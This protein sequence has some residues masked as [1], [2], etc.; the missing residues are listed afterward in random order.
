MRVSYGAKF[1]VGNALALHS[2]LSSSALMATFKAGLRR[3][4]RVPH[5]ISVRFG[6]QAGCHAAGRP[7]FWSHR[8]PRP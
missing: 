6:S 1:E 8:K 2:K 7:P 5:G 4:V 3:V